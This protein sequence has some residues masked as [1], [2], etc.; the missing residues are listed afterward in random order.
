MMDDNEYGPEEKGKLTVFRVMRALLGVGS[1][2]ALQRMSVNMMPE[3]DY[4]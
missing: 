2:A 3:Y 4:E 1:E